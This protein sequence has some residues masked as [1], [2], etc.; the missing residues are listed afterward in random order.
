MRADS[1]FPAGAVFVHVRLHEPTKAELAAY[2]SGDAIARRLEAL[3]VPAG[4][5]E[6]IEVVVSLTTG[7]G[8]KVT[9]N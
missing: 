6:A 3:V 1:R 4:R 9:C 7:A 2:E 8:A 5:L